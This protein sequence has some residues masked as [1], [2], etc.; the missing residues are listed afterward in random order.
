MEET[1]TVSA[2][3]TL[4]KYPLEVTV[5]GPGSGAVK[6]IPSGI[7]C[8]ADC[9]EDYGYGTQVTLTAVVSPGS[10]FTGWRGACNGFGS[11][12]VAMDRARTVLAEFG[13][14]AEPVPAPAP[15][16]VLTLTV[17]VDGGGMVTS[18]PDGIHCGSECS[19]TYAKGAA[20]TLAAAADDGYIF[21][22]WGAACSGSGT[23]E[24]M[25]DAPMNVVAIFSAIPSAKPSVSIATAVIL[26]VEPTELR[27]FEAFKLAAVVQ[28]TSG[29]SE[30]TGTLSGI[31]ALAG[32]VEF[33]ANDQKLGS[34]T[35]AAGCRAEMVAE[36]GLAPGQYSLVAR[37]SGDAQSQASASPAVMITVLVDVRDEIYLPALR[38]NGV[39]SKRSQVRASQERILYLP[40]LLR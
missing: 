24:L 28:D 12:A 11:C 3:F 39:S 7:A 4:K 9:A 13:K 34:A 6:S 29:D 21:E 27:S 25:M 16:S 10:T 22:G 20:V 35:P 37:Y 23:C 30:L 8:G 40:A 36:T 2:E 31:C 17:I 15:A 1:K 5:G 32:A 18:I 19:Q 14:E 38:K 26:S 33:L